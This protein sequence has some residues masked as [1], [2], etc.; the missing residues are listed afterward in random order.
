MSEYIIRTSNL[1]KYYSEEKRTSFFSLRSARSHVR[2]VE[3]INLSI[4]K[5][6]AL[7]LV[8]ESGCGKSTLGKI[9]IRLEEPTSGNIF[10]NNQD[11]TN[12]PQGELKN[13]RKKF[14]IIFQDPSSSLNPRKTVFQI[15]SQPLKVHGIASDKK[16][17]LNRVVDL[18]EKVGL[19]KSHME[20]YPHQFSGGQRQRICIARAISLD[21]IFLVADEVVSAL[22]VSVQAQILN[23]LVLLKDDLNLSILFIS[24]DLSV[25]RQISDR[26][27][28]MYLGKIVELSPSEDLFTKPLH[29]YTQALMSAIPI[30]DAGIVWNPILL[31]GETPNPSQHPRGCAFHPRCQKVFERCKKEEVTLREIN[32]GHFAACHLWE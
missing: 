12:L 18:L 6:E 16:E 22:D 23:L 9:I 8:G 15:L 3:L 11:I 32:P 17:I 21:P 4:K 2:A 14:Q 28:V 24:H 7:G 5:N 31:E 25:V 10:F 20:R 19:E 26:V 30:P 13:L 1:R 27:A 29:P